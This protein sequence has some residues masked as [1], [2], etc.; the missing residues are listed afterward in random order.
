MEIENI[1]NDIDELIVLYLSEGLKPEDAQRLEQWV[2]A[3]AENL[4]YFSDKQ[5]IWIG[6]LNTSTSLHFNKDAAYGRFL[7]RAK[8]P[9]QPAKSISSK[10]SLRRRVWYSAAVVVLLICA[11]AISYWQGGEMLKTRFT[12]IVVEAPLGSQTKMYLP[13][14]TLVWLNA[15]SRISYSQGFGVNE[16]NI[17][18]I[19]EGYF[20]VTKSE[21]L[22]FAV[23]TDE[24]TINVLGTKF[25]FNNYPDNEEASVSLVEGKVMARNNIRNGNDVNLMPNQKLFLNKK[26]GEMRISKMEAKRSTE[27]TN[28]NLFFDEEILPDIIK[29]LERDYDVSITLADDSLKTFRFYG[30][31]IKRDCRI[32]DILDML[33]STGKIKYKV[34]G[35]QIELSAK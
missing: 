30:S 25:N 11:S 2:G 29:E 12:D 7:L 16:R 9:L 5:E 32:E 4:K 24:L 18:L 15:G 35:K 19:G 33:A 13:D 14:G 28:G 1:H 26:T 8:K 20:E 34:E 23:M 21:K 17:H 27:W 3:S 31:F 6:T 10:T 22:A